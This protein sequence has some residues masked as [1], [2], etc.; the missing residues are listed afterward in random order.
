VKIYSSII[1]I[2]STVILFPSDSFGLWPFTPGAR[3]PYLARVG[4]EL[5]T[6]EEF[7]EEMDKLHKSR[8]V[9][10]ALA[11][12]QSFTVQDYKKFLDELIEKRLMA[13]EAVSLGLDSEKDF[14]SALNIYKLN[15]F[16]QRLREDEIL[17]KVK[18]ED[19]EIEQYYLEQLEKKKEESH[20]EEPKEMTQ[21]DR[22]AIRSG[23]FNEKVKEPEKQYFARLRE[24]ATIEIKTDLLSSV[25][26]DNI[27]LRNKAVAYVNG[28]PILG[29]ELLREFRTSDVNDEEIVRATLERLISH[30]LL[31]QEAMA[32]ARGYEEEEEIKKKIKKYREKLLIKHFKTKAILP[33]VVVEEEDVL[34][35][36]EE[37]KD[38]YREPDSVHLGVIHVMEEERAQTIFNDLKEGADFVFLASSESIDPSRLRGGDKGWVNIDQLPSVMRNALNGAKQ[39]D[40]LG[41]FRLR[42]GYGIIE[43]RGLEKGEYIPFG[44]VKTNI[45]RAIGREK[46]D[47]TL[48]QYLKRLREIV[49]VKINHKELERFEGR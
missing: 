18:V 48:K 12:E 25:S 29:I 42:Y 32:R 41:P 20:K 37:N 24:E 3:E 19:E 30:K 38:S 47:A 13:I 28:E 8:R 35:Y 36:Y 4:D 40:V 27:E 9:G 33:A 44:K 6:T 26:P 2:I 22:E 14:V 39:G 11:E 10:K 16:L 21:R 5:I 49:P 34:G 17:S 15:L 46:F 1:L 7:V 45:D 43:F 23:L 31:D